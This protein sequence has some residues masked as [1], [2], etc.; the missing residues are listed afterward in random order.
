MKCELQNEVLKNERKQSVL[1]II[2]N[3]VNFKNNSRVLK[4]GRSL[5]KYGYDVE[6][7]GL[8][9][10]GLLEKEET[11]CGM[12]VHRMRLKS[13]SW[14]NNWFL[15]KLKFIEFLFSSLLKY[16][17]KVD[18]IVCHDLNTLPVGVLIKRFS[19]NQVNIVYDAHEYEIETNGETKVGRFLKKK[20]E[21]WLIKYA[22]SV[23]CVSDSIANEY[24]RIYGIDKPDLILNCPNYSE[25][26]RLDL[27]RDTFPI[28]A[29]QKIF[30]Y[31][32]G[33]YKG[34]GIEILLEAFEQLNSDDNVLVCMG[35]GPLEDLVKEKADTS[36][37]VFFQPAVSPDILLN[38]TS[39][40]DFGILFYEDTCLNHRYCS[41]NKMFEYIM[42]GIPVLVSNLFEMK[43]LV[44]SLG[45]GIVAETNDV[46]G[47]I[48]AIE[49]S[50][51]QSYSK[52]V[53]NVIKA[54]KQFSWEEQEKVLKEVFD[55]I[56]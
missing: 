6:V 44:E 19:S 51:D 20:L 50:I 1:A 17:D 4:Q 16:K 18:I 33:L 30:L 32:G 52:C 22:A 28:R 24:H 11:S 37:R 9:E 48:E 54:R 5:I 36:N 56:N 42:A 23:I 55:E 13:T 14:K 21:G 41:P 12:K 53:D 35:F 34:R 7:L 46:V 43:R 29:N 38:F 10:D 49:S 47:F 25:Q 2:F 31:Q 26:Q 15:R 8:F 39:S 40:A 27:F 45:V 3:N